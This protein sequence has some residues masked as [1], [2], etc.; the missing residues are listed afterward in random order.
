MDD[1]TPADP[2]LAEA[3]AG[4]PEWAA[5]AT[6]RL[7]SELSD[8]SFAEVAWVAET[9]STNADL[10]DLAR[11]DPT[12]TA[13][14]L[15]ES[16]SAGRG[17]QGRSWQAPPGSGLML[18][19]LVRPRLPPSQAHLLTT[20]MGL[21]ALESLDLE[22][23]HREVVGLK[24]PNDLVVETDAG[25]RKLGG[26]LAESIVVGDDLGAVVVGIGLNVNWPGELPAELEGIATSVGHLTG[27]T[28]DRGRLA[29]RLLRSFDSRVGDLGTAAGRSHTVNA[30][31][32]ACVTVG[33]QVRVQLARGE[34]VGTARAVDEDGRLVVVDEQGI[35]HPLAVGD[36]THLRPLG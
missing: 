24:W 9:G 30:Y 19:V 22:E 3:G 11:R 26:I 29:A 34:V 5:E 20:A 1:P 17:R 2:E 7:R 28:T 27:R 12:A 16:Q 23:R 32:E 14:L 8:T 21:A 25:T 10:L 4:T 6:D 13:V 33:R 31:V 15:A 35:E 36:V 18:S